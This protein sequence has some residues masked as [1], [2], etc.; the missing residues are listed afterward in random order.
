MRRSIDY[1][2]TKA[3]VFCPEFLASSK[4]L[5][6]WACVNLNTPFSRMGF[7]SSGGGDLHVMSDDVDHGAKPTVDD[8]FACSFCLPLHFPSRSRCFPLPLSPRP[9]P[10]LQQLWS[11][12]L[13][14][15][16]SPLAQTSSPLRGRSPCSFGLG[17]CRSPAWLSWRMRMVWQSLTW[18]TS[19]LGVRRYSRHRRF[20][21]CPTRY[22]P[23]RGLVSSSA[24]VCTTST[25]QLRRRARR[26]QWRCLNASGSV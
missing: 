13:A 15:S 2:L 8:S 18:S 20:R 16:S 22:P 25:R 11:W 10:P 6:F 26:L 1:W 5:I 24:C 14:T 23:R 17:P 21:S 4:T 19:R 7:I 12:E 3:N 9:R